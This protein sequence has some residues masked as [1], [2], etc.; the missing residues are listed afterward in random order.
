MTSLVFRKQI[1]NRPL[2]THQI[3]KHER[4][5]ERMPNSG[6]DGEKG[7]SSYAGW[8]GTDTGALM[9]EGGHPTVPGNKQ[10]P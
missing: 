5:R 6:K 8:W 10:T 9:Q 7:G 2:Y 3:A 1:R 4:E